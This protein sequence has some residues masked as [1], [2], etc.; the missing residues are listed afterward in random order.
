M[1]APRGVA[2]QDTVNNALVAAT[3]ELLISV[4]ARGIKT[5]AKVLVLGSAHITDDA[6]AATHRNA[7]RL[8]RGSA[9]AD[10]QIGE[11][12]T[13]DSLTGANLLL[14]NAIMAFDNAPTDDP[15]Y[16]L[17]ALDTHADTVT[18]SSI[19]VIPIG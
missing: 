15:V 14:T 2:A 13:I 5:G 4:Q 9:V 1:S 7:L 11:D 12:A 19:V 18:F 10:T 17:F 8:R 3:E 16:G 6:T